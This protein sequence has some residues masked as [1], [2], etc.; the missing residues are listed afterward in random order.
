MIKLPTDTIPKRLFLTGVPGS[1]WSGIAQEIED[2]VD[3]DCS[4]RTENRRFTHSNFSGHVG[5]YFGSGMEFPAVL[6]ET[7]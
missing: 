4:D 1:R 7:N 6:S 5:A 2:A 3:A